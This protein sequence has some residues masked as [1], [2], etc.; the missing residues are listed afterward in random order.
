LLLMFNIWK[1][2]QSQLSSTWEWKTKLGNV[3]VMSLSKYVNTCLWDTSR[4]DKGNRLWINSLIYYSWWP[5]GKSKN[6]VQSTM[7]FW[8]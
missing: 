7:H 4:K 8:T 5:E 2:K 6:N 3:V 1:L